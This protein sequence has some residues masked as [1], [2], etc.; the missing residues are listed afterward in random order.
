M[1]GFTNGIAIL[2]ASTQIRDAFGLQTSDMPGAFL[3]RVRVLASAGSASAVA[4]LLAL[5]TIATV[6]LCRRLLPRI[7]GSIV[8]LAA[9]TI[10]VALTGLQ[11]ETIGTRSAPCRPA[12]RSCTCRRSG[13]T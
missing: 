11:V 3:D 8:A 7:P 5:S 10:A 4:T 9:S 2:I 12:C 6:L 13:R 1:I